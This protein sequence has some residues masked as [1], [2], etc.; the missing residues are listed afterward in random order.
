M[1][2]TLAEWPETLES[3]IITVKMVLPGKRDK[4]AYAAAL[5]KETEETEELISRMEEEQES[6]E[7]EFIGSLAEG[8]FGT[9]SFSELLS[10]VREELRTECRRCWK[11]NM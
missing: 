9:G 4:H 3:E 7:T 8:R 2:S 1:G 11:C 10:P 6:G 5:T